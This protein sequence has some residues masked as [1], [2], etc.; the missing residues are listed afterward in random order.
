MPKTDR[1]VR[2]KLMMVDANM[3][4]HNCHPLPTV[5]NIVSFVELNPSVIESNQTSKAS[6]VCSTVVAFSSLASEIEI[7]VINNSAHFILR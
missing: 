2:I 6:V 1:F 7:K 4:S 5:S 3:T